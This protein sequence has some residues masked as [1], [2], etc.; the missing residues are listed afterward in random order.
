MHRIR[1]IKM[2]IISLL[3]VMV[4]VAVV[5][6]IL[7]SLGMRVMPTPE[8]VRRQKMLIVQCIAVEIVA[9]LAFLTVPVLQSLP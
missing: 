3:L 7:Y 6:G 9:I 4:L 5:F 8:L 2:P 1:E